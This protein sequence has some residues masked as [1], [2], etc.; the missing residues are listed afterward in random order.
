M[1]KITKMVNT[2]M[3]NVLWCVIFFCSTNFVLGC[4]WGFYTST[5]N[6]QCT[7]CAPGTGTLSNQSDSCVR[8][9]DS[10][11]DTGC[12]FVNN[13]C[14]FQQLDFSTTFRCPAGSYQFVNVVIDS[15]L[16]GSYQT[17]EKWSARC[18]KCPLGKFKSG[19]NSDTF[20]LPCNAGYYA[21]SIG[22]SVCTD[23]A[24]GTYMKNAWPR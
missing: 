3:R 22:S 17:Q 9:C 15:T 12:L 1:C 11:V 13:I 20:C 21:S 7:Q 18:I 14:K 19:Y 23:C 8:S 4:G 6:N 10:A 5:L 16:C 24:P 2:K